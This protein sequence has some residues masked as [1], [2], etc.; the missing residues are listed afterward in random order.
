[1]FRR[2]WLLLPTLIFLLACLAALPACRKKSPEGGGVEAGGATPAAVSTEHLLF[3]HLKAKDVRDGAVFK[4]IQKAI[5][6]TGA[7]DWNIVEEEASK[8]FG[9]KPTEVD[10]VTVC[11]AEVPDRGEPKLVMI[12]TTSKPVDKGRAF[13]SKLDAKPDA[14]GFY[15]SRGLSML[16]H[17]PDDKT[18]VAIHPDLADKYLGGYA[19]DHAGWPFTEELSKAAAG[20]TLFAVVNMTKLPDG[21]FNQRE[22]K[23][24][25]PLAK[26]KSAVVVADLKDKELSV[27]V[28]GEFP[29][30]ASAGQ[31]K[32]AIQRGIG[33]ATD[34]IEKFMQAGRDL[35]VVMPAVKEAHRALKEA[36]VEA[37]GSEVTLQGNYRADFDVGAVVVEG[38]KQVRLA[39]TKSQSQNNLKQMVLG[40]HNCA[41]VN[42]DRILFRGTDKDGRIVMNLEGKPLLSWRVALLPFIEQDE[43]YKQFKLD[44][45]WDSPNNKRLIEKMPKTYAMPGK[46]GKPGYTPYQMVVGPAAQRRPFNHNGGNARTTNTDCMVEA[47][48]PVIWTKPDDIEFPGKELPKDFRKKFGGYF[49]GGFNVGMFD[50][51]VRWVSDKVSNHALALALDPYDGNPLPNDW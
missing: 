17:F 38:L 26:A 6:K 16:V 46:E 30:A 34:E 43:L 3:A 19:K 4:E 35:N 42:G 41:G 45:P 7:A 9:F 24:F 5:E 21:I 49:P 50:G 12:V 22:L 28:R 25:A 8:G 36:K 13:G 31:A 2:P 10:S 37:S 11:V 15:T 27:A 51:S 23:D 29:D 40:L 33:T 20:H 39:A 14:R 47:A 48:E 44:E 1:M 18:F 32:D